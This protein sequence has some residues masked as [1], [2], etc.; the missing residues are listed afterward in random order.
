MTQQRKP[1]TIT[2][3]RPRQSRNIWTKL[4]SVIPFVQMSADEQVLASYPLPTNTAKDPNHTT[5][6]QRPKWSQMGPS[7]AK[8]QIVEIEDCQC[9]CWFDSP[10]LGILLL[11]RPFF[12]PGC[13]SGSW[14]LE[15][16]CKKIPWDWEISRVPFSRS[17]CCRQLR[18]EL[19]PSRTYHGPCVLIWDCQIHYQ[20]K[21][22]VRL[23]ITTKI[24]TREAGVGAKRRRFIQVPHNLGVSYTLVS[25]AILIFL[26]SLQFL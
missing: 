5:V 3:E 16:K 22:E 2:I 14:C 9:A 23:P 4:G 19:E 6:V 13:I 21:T 7:D 11:P 26:L 1:K 10:S 17:A 24:Q 18:P 15:Q 8:V 20:T 25:K 12:W